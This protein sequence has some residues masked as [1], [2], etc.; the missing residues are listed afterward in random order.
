[1]C[2]FLKCQISYVLAQIW[3]IKKFLK[4]R[5]LT[6]FS[7]TK[8]KISLKIVKHVLY[9]FQLVCNWG[10]VMGT[11]HLTQTEECYQVLVFWARYFLCFF[12]VQKFV[13]AKSVVF[14]KRMRHYFISFFS[15]ALQVLCLCQA[16][17]LCP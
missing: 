16:E 2:A 15:A 3:K 5:Q 17:F 10:C 14:P 12:M 8:M 13:S 9:Q 11:M 1:M 6:D 4:N 7:Y